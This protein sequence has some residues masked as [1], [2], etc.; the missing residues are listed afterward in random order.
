[1]QSV[2]TKFS[3]GLFV[4]VGMTTVILVVLW[5]GMSEYFKETRRY[6]AYFDESVQGLSRDAAVKYRGVNVGKVEQ[7]NVAP[8]G[9]LIEIVFTVSKTLQDTGALVAQLKSVGITGI[10]YMELEKQPP[11]E[12]ISRPEFS[13]T[14]KHPVVVTRPSEMKQFLSDLYE[15]LSRIK[16]VD[17]EG[18]STQLSQLMINTNMILKDAQIDKLSE[19]LQQAIENSNQ[20][21]DSEKWNRLQISAEST[22]KNFDGLVSDTRNAVKKVD[23]NIAESAGHFDSAVA[24]VRKA[25]G[26]AEDVFAKGS[27][28]LDA[29]GSRAGD[30]DRHLVEIIEELREATVRLNLLIEQVQ[31]QPSRILY[32]PPMPA[33]QV[34]PEKNR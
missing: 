34:E 3:V 1:M 29:A 21:L 8:D 7:I 6:A 24:E 27:R 33:K 32:G 28:G 22:I 2:R 23:A 26:T 14:P 30:Y 17:V 12:K 5:L 20:L 4:I 11:E 15:I 10:M 31:N 25:A 19:G 9:R 16:Q 18:I 13:F